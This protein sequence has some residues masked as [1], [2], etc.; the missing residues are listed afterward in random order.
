[1]QPGDVL[2]H[3]DGKVV[4]DDGQ[5]VLR[6]DE[7]IQHRYLLRGKGV[8][9]TT[10]F[11]VYRKG[12]GSVETPACVLGD[13]P[14]IIRRWVDVDYNPDYLIMGAMVLL[15]LSW[16]LR[17]HKRCGTRLIAESIDWCHK[18]PQDYEGKQNLVALVDIFAHELTFSYNRPWR[19]VTHYNGI[20]INSLGHL[21]DMWHESCKAA[22]EAVAAGDSEPSFARIELQT[23]D[24]IV[25]E[26]QAAMAAESEI[27]KRHQIPKASHI[28]PPNPNYI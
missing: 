27:L 1:M 13:I 11:T 20:A 18:F 4:N 19:R 17:S 25:L 21:R 5:V 10:Q 9:E 16:S 8:D 14:S 24:D 2:T 15:P 28:S 3:I 7:L 26:V 12:Q 6:R 23:D 22:Q